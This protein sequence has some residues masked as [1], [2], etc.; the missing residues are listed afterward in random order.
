MAEGRFA[1]A[2]PYLEQVSLGFLAQQNISWYMANR[3]Y[4][5]PRW[6]TRQTAKQED[7][8]GPGKGEPKENLKV[9]YCKDMVQLQASYNLARD[10]GQKEKQAYQLGVM[11]YQASCYGDCWFLTHYG[12]SVYDSARAGERDFA[13]EAVRYLDVAKRS[14]DPTMR[15]KAIYALAYMPVDPWFRSTWDADYNMVYIA[16]PQSSQYKAMADLYRFAKENPQHVDH[17][18]TRCDMLKAFVKATVRR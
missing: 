9:R 5:V 18:T 3:T 4:D 7:T 13:A 2:L 12:R 15:Y 10:G 17:Y 14:A 6:F 1:E 8:D 16:Q 11:Y